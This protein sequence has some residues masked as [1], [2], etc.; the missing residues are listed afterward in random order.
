[1]KTILSLCDYT[2]AWPKPY[3]DAGYNVIQ[4]DIKHGQDVRL[5]RVDGLPSIHG[6][7]AAPPCTHFAGSGARWW[8]EKG[9]AALLEGLGVV[10][11][12]LRIITA[13]KPK[14]WALENPVGRLNHYLGEPSFY[15]QPCDYGD[16]YTKKT[17]LWGD[18]TP[19]IGLFIERADWAVEATEG[20]KM[21]RLPPSAERQ[22][23]RSVT[24]AGFAQAF[25]I[26][27]P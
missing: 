16:P 2:G 19:P 14:W 5:L 15:F 3:K 6:V 21:H 17:A 13:V 1:M 25:F 20:S 8:K 4:I 18:F 24:P 11:A 9:T 12:C 10:D 22:A 23:L 26:A 27:N 7:L